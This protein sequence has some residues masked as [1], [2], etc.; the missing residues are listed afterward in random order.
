MTPRSSHVVFMIVL[1]SV[2]N[3]CSKHIGDQCAQNIECSLNA[4]RTCDTTQPNGYCTVVDCDPN[5]CP[6]NALCVEFDSNTPRLA[7][8][9]C[10]ES[11]ANPNDPQHR[12]DGNCGSGDVCLPVV[13]TCPAD[14]GPP[15][16]VSES[17]MYA[18]CST[19]TRVLDTTIPGVPLADGG[20]VG[21]A[22]LLG[23]CVAPATFYRAP[24]RR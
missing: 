8:R 6:D 15:P 16:C 23:Y 12:G 19:C 2:A 13:P 22:P 7:R 1:A 17:G 4:D 5:Q 21:G 3:A 24:P 18:T 11:C 14:A 20:T 9:Y 10:V